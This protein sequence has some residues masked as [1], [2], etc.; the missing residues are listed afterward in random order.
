ML[1]LTRALFGL[2]TISTI[3]SLFI[4]VKDIDA[5]I[6]DRFLIGYL[7][8]AIFVLIYTLIITLW[9]SR[10]LTWVEMRKR[11]SGFIIYSILLGTSGYVLDKV[12]RPSDVDLLREFSIAFGLSF[13]FSF[14]DLI[15]FNKK[16]K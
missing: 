5:N 12:Y 2:F 16:A 14:I 15:F 8:L 11:I 4:V 7:F 6:T 13:G 3:I 1:F 10:K 9:K